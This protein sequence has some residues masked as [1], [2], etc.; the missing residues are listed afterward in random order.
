MET[1][2]EFATK[3]AVNAP[4][5][6]SANIVFRVILITTTVLTGLVAS[7]GLI[8]EGWKVE[9]MAILKGIDTIVWAVSRLF[10]VVIEKE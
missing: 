9:I 6:K 1:K 4:T 3:A 10:G 2:V 5:P 7:T 8:D